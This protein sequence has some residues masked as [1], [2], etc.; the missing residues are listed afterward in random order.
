MVIWAIGLLADMSW[1]AILLSTCIS[2]QSQPFA[3][4]RDT[5]N[6]CSS[7]MYGTSLYN[8][9]LP[10]RDCVAFA[11]PWGYAAPE[12]GTEGAGIKLEVPCLP[13]L[14]DGAIPRCNV[15]RCRAVQDGWLLRCLCGSSSFCTRGG[16]G[17][18]TKRGSFPKAASLS[19]AQGK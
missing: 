17:Y 8:G 5:E 18:P 15:P 11:T 14:R 7:P 19:M 2:D 3:C 6:N 10:E 4:T 16:R 13:L 12:R 9:G 1:G